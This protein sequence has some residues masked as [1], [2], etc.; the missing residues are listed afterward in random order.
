VVPAVVQRVVHG[1][2]ALHASQ[3]WYSGVEPWVP[4]RVKSVEETEVRHKNN[5]DV[6]NIENDDNGDVDREHEELLGEHWV[7]IDHGR[8]HKGK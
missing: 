7:S 8:C 2:T 5:S 1:T 3:G 4:F 6:V